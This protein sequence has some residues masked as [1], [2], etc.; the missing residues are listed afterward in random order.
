MEDACKEDE[1]SIGSPLVGF[2]P[3]TLGCYSARSYINL[4]CPVDKSSKSS[5]LSGTDDLITLVE[6]IATALRPASGEGQSPIFR[7]GQ[8]VFEMMGKRVRRK[9]L[10]RVE[11][12]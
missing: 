11:S 7:L 10:L 6:R 8:V 4:P 2:I 12:Q 9:R 1:E 3:S 5:G